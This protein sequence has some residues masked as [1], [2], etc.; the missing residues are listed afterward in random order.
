MSSL[1]LKDPMLISLGGNALTGGKG[2]ETIPDQRAAA[3]VACEIVAKVFRSGSRMALVHG[4]GPQSGFI[5]E[6]FGFAEKHGVLHSVPFDAIVADT[7]GAIGYMLEQILHNILVGETP[8]LAN[9]IATLVTQAVV[10]RNDPDFKD[11]SKP[12][13]SWMT[14]ADARRREAEDKWVVRQLSNKREDGWRRVVP[15]PKPISVTNA[16]AIRH[17]VNSGLLTICGGGGGIPVALREDGTLEGVE[18]VID[19]DAISAVIAAV[20]K[21]R[22]LTILTEAPGVIDPKDYERDGIEGRVI[23]V[24]NLSEAKDMQLQRG[25]MGPKVAACVRFTEATGEPSLIANFANAEEAF[26]GCAG[27]QIVV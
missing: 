23:P 5:A 8:A 26:Q 3:Q 21:A 24:L 25:S 14:E 15:S 16:H 2:K 9:G 18:A 17:N 22:L 27:T 13:G 4:N 6:R 10:D 20:I 12:I 11:P 19:K 7:Q 1:S